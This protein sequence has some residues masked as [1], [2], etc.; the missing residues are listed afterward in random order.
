MA[1][2]D[3]ATSDIDLTDRFLV[4]PYEN[5]AN[6]EGIPVHLDFG[7]DLLALETAR[8]DRFDARGCFAHTHGRGDFMANYVLEIEA[9]KKTAPIKH[10]YEAFIYVLE[11]H[12]TTRIWLPSGEEQTFEWGP[13]AMFAVPLNCQYQIFNGS[14]Q[15][16]VR[17]SCTNDA[18]LT[19]NLYHNE[20]FVST[21]LSPS[22]SASGHPIASK[23]KASWSRLTGR[24]TPGGSISGRPT[25]ST[26]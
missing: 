1:E 7:H 19:L 22:L 6:G 20:K 25:S 11:G 26:T 14:G 13:K 12:G 16:K 15:E 10:L 8:W 5:W 4:D 21:I 2:K 18:P 23:V 9:G 24:Q 3:G 17:L